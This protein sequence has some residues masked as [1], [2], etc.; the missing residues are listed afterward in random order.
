M[1]THYSVG[2]HPML[3]IYSVQVN[4]QVHF[5]Q[6]MFLGLIWSMIGENRQFVTNEPVEF[7]K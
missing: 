5:I 4:G 3:K 1:A 2:V 7:E 6:K